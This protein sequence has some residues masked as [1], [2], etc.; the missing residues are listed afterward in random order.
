[1]DSGYFQRETL[2]LELLPNILDSL[3]MMSSSLAL[4]QWCIDFAFEQGR[5]LHQKNPR[6]LK[7]R[8][9]K[10]LTQATQASTPSKEL[11]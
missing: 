4:Q 5:T 9:S 8:P 1:M 11:L 3:E 6:H 7:H 10:Y 2:A